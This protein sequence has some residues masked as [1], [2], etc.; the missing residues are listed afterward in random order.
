LRFHQ[1]DSSFFYPS[2]YAYNTKHLS[3]QQIVRLQDRRQGNLYA[4]L[5]DKKVKR[6]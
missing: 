1:S 3:P 2:K 5:T 4:Y 6:P